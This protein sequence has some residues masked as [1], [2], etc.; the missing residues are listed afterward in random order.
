MDSRCPEM[1][2]AGFGRGLAGDDRWRHRHRARGPTL[3]VSK[4]IFGT[5]QVTEVRLSVRLYAD[6]DA[7][8]VALLHYRTIRRADVP[9]CPL[10]SADMEAWP[11]GPI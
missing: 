10:T 2:H 7:S 3:Q 9:M 8:T 6:D 5:S 1:R 11:C 4:I